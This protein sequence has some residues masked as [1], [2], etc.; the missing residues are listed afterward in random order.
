M[1]SKKTGTTTK[2]DDR[3]AARRKFLQ[4]G[5]AFQQQY[6]LQ[7]CGPE[8]REL[9][10]LNS[11]FDK[12]GLE[13]LKVMA[14]LY[15]SGV[16]PNFFDEYFS[17][18]ERSDITNTAECRALVWHEY[19]GRRWSYAK[20]LA[21]YHSGAIQKLNREVDQVELWRRLHGRSNE[22]FTWYFDDKRKIGDVFHRPAV[23][24]T[25]GVSVLHANF[26]N[27]PVCPKHTL[28]FGSTHVAIGFVDLG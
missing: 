7:H 14:P 18:I 13:G 1:T 3:D 28:R 8:S 2:T 24:Y 11:M 25:G 22:L 15:R 5:Q 12:T 6:K 21:G 20:H 27:C 26:A 23:K 4:E 17:N 19:E 16:N 10:L 9:S